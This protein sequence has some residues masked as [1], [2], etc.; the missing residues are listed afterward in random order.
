VQHARPRCKDPEV[1]IRL[2]G[3]RGA[4]SANTA[5]YSMLRRQMARL[6]IRLTGKRGSHVFRHARAAT[7]LR[8]GVP[9]KTIG[10]LLGH[11]S[12]SSTAVYLKLDDQELRNVALPL[13]LPEVS[14]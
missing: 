4:F 10:D 14:P 7:L 5:L 11:R 3:P 6:G 13:P 9:L 12:A 1:F 2:S 8:A